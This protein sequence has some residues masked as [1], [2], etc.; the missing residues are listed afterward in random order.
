MDARVS[1]EVAGQN[2]VGRPLHV[3]GY[4]SRT[5]D[6]FAN[7]TKKI[8]KGTGGAGQLGMFLVKHLSELLPFIT[9]GESLL[10]RPESSGKAR[11]VGVGD[12]IVKVDK[13]GE[14]EAPGI[15]S[16]TRRRTQSLNFLPVDPDRALSWLWKIG[17]PPPSFERVS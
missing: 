13:A 2:S 8:E 6:Q 17:S 7:F 5:P 12:V 15:D 16:V 4:R 9:V 14:N 11:S 3:V 1:V 10:L